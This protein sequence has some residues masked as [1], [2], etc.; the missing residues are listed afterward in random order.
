MKLY[1]DEPLG[2]VNLTAFKSLADR[3]YKLIEGSVDTPATIAIHGV[4]GSGRT[5]FM[6]TLEKKLS[7]RSGEKRKNLI[8]WFHPQMHR[9]ERELQYAFLYVLLSKIR[10][11]TGDNVPA[12]QLSEA[13]DVI[14]QG[15]KGLQPILN[16]ERIK[17]SISDSIEDEKYKRVVFFIDDLDRCTPAIAFTMLETMKFFLA[18]IKH[19]I[20]ILSADMNRLKE[21]ISSYY[22]RSFTDKEI[23][24]MFSE[25]YLERMIQLRVDLPPMTDEIY[26]EY[27][28]SLIGD[29]HPLFS[30]YLRIIKASG[31][32]LRQIKHILNKAQFLESL[33]PKKPDKIGAFIFAWTVIGFINPKFC[34]YI[35]DNPRLLE[36]YIEEA[37]A[38]K[39]AEEQKK[40]EVYSDA[41]LSDVMLKVVLTRTMIPLLAI[42]SKYN[43]KEY[44]EYI[45]PFTKA[46]KE[47]EEIIKTEFLSKNFEKQLVIGANW[48]YAIATRLKFERARIIDTSARWTDFSHS[49]F[50]DA[51]I[52]GMDM[53]SAILLECTFGNSRIVR[54]KFVDAVLT[55]AN[56]NDA[57]EI[58]GCEFTSARMRGARFTSIKEIYGCKFDYANISGADFSRSTLT[59]CSFRSAIAQPVEEMVRDKGGFKRKRH[60][61]KFKE[62]EFLGVDAE[63][64]FFIETDFSGAKLR[65]ANLKAVNARG[66]NFSGADL[67]AIIGNGADFSRIICD[68]KT[69]FSSAVLVNATFEGAKL[70]G[71]NFLGAD[72]KGA[73]FLEIEY[74]DK[75]LE[76]IHDSWEKA[77][78]IKAPA[79][80]EPEVEKKLEGIKGVKKRT[81]EKRSGR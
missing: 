52:F 54:S 3:L 49:T 31:L 36:R 67:S 40:G 73:K 65:A 60:I 72:I 63:R 23:L 16:M 4:E 46:E 42:L 53:T 25:R 79:I 11:N 39:N 6:R 18:D 55:E 69:N 20:F 15:W 19:L 76:S 62:T 32:T 48:N 8:I 43:P 74:D 59:S 17:K 45:I 33:I 50:R 81:R 1:P 75:F 28:K 14:T 61:T 56:F 29:K 26:E 41:G 22:S 66:A 44:I 64:A 34:E 78:K 30:D 68:D 21:T 5:T 47:K 12:N 71:A 80:F 7:E 9:S 13:I 58:S 38:I 24:Y 37:E 10:H 77:K 35:E 70:R 51:E 27:L 57:R 2:E